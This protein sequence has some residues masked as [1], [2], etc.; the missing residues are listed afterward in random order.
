MQLGYNTNGF[1]FHRLED[2]IDIIAELG[3]QC[4]ALTLDVHH[5]DPFEHE[6]AWF[7]S[8]AE[9]LRRHKLSCVVETGAR[10]LLNPRLKHRPT[11]LDNDPRLRVQFLNKAIEIAETLGA[12]VVSLWSGARPEG[13]QDSDDELYQRLAEHLAPIVERGKAAGISVALEPE[14]GF[15]IESM[16]DYERLCGVLGQRVPLTLDV[17]HLRCVEAAPEAEF[18]ERYREEVVNVQLDDMRAGQ[19]LHLPFGTG[20]VD[21]PAVFAALASI[22][23]TGPACVELSDASR[24]A[25][26]VARE[27]MVFLKRYGGGQ[28]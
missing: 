20:E 27:S 14:P 10:F 16:A 4:V 3:Y 7:R 19:H 23:Y 24:N 18:I 12:A 26:T 6:T 21:F 8:L 22:G 13:W 5:A 2:A 17:G 9:R 1:G 15:L 11:L 25:V 28:V